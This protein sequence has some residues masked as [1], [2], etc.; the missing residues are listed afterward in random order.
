MKPM[1]RV[2][3]GLVFSALIL[4]L[5][6]T[7][8]S[9]D[10]PHA[11]QVR[12]E[13][14]KYTQGGPDSDMV[15]IGDPHAQGGQGLTQLPSPK[16]TPSTPSTPP[17]DQFP[18][19]PIMDNFYIPGGPVIIGA[20]HSANDPITSWNFDPSGGGAWGN[21]RWGDYS[22]TTPEPTNWT[23]SSDNGQTWHNGPL[24]G[25][26]G[27]SDSNWRY[28]ERMYRRG[29]TRGCGDTSRPECQP[30]HPLTRGEMEVFIIRA[31]MNSVFP[32]VTNGWGDCIGPSCFPGDGQFPHMNPPLGNEIHF[33]PTQTRDLTPQF[34]TLVGFSDFPDFLQNQLNRP[35]HELGPREK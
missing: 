8:Y 25:A 20:P 13:V 1:P 2:F 24:P 5:A 16:E 31:K 11:Q 29:Y 17:A 19:I 30:G 10:S 14:S 27:Q 32:T 21:N 23:W 3:M 15:Q 34:G 33:I 6:Q 7:G 4:S 12:D 18:I 26:D 35:L 22:A 28:I 9:D